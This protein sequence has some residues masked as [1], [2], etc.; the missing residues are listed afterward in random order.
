M[1][2]DSCSLANLSRHLKL[3]CII[4]VFGLSFGFLYTVSL[5]SKLAG[6]YRRETDFEIPKLSFPRKR[7]S[8][9]GS[10]RGFPIKDFGNDTVAANLDSYYSNYSIIF[11][12]HYTDTPASLIQ[13]FGLLR[14]VRPPDRRSWQHC[15]GRIQAEENTLL[16]YTSLLP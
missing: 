1:Q 3:F 5:V 8:K 14:K 12:R 9:N 2:R 15:P 10:R 13:T 11:I 7:E 4:I 6:A 16:Y